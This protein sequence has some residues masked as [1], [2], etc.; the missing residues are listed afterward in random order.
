MDLYEL[1]H[2]AAEQQHFLQNNNH[3]YDGG[4]GGGDA[5]GA[6]EAVPKV[7]PRKCSAG[8]SGSNYNAIQKCTTVDI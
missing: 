7:L 4:G 1:N 8:A 2:A 6:G 3:N 5:G